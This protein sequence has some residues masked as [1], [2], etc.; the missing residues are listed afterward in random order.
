VGTF[1]VVRS[2]C[3]EWCVVGGV[4]QALETL[5][6]MMLCIASMREKEISK[7]EGAKFL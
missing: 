4:D 3:S 5:A 6:R 2:D 1:Y 7:E